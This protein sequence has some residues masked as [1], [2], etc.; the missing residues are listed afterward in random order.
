MTPH[1]EPIPDKTTV[2]QESALNTQS[3]DVEMV[4]AERMSSVGIN[5]SL[6]GADLRV[7]VET[8]KA[9]SG[10]VPAPVKGVRF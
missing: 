9:S 7:S 1:E 5:A 8:A 2:L 4:R 6:S 3:E 10:T